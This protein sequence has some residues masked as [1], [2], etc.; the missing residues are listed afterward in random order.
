MPDKKTLSERD[1]CT[2][3]ITPALEKVGWNMQ[4]QLL[5]EVWISKLEN[6]KSCKLSNP[7]SSP[8]RAVPHC[9]QIG[10]VDGKL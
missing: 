5:E 8:S 7:P 6:G 9:S 2:K 10:A 4:S 3:F 1:I